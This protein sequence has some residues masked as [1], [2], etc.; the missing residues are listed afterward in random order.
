MRDGSE[1]LRNYFF[2]RIPAHF[3]I[4]CYYGMHPIETILYRRLTLPALEKFF[5]QPQ[6]R[7]PRVQRTLCWSIMPSSDGTE[8]RS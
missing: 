1:L 3:Y 2:F 7:P 5:V 8:E 6:A 4:R